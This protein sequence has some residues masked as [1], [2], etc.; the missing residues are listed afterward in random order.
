M[1]NVFIRIENET[2]IPR[3]VARLVEIYTSTDE[4]IHKLIDEADELTRLGTDDDK[5]ISMI[6]DEIAFLDKVKFHTQLAI[7]MIVNEESESK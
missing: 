3:S 7:G 4:R 1:A 5:V 2:E 6:E